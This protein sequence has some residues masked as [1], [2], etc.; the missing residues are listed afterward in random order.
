MVMSNVTSVPNI[1]ANSYIQGAQPP[2]AAPPPP[3]KPLDSVGQPEEYIQ[4]AMN[5][6]T[7]TEKAYYQ[8]MLNAAIAKPMIETPPPIS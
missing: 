8:A 4:G 2:Q 3:V 1:A 5:A 7:E 6:K